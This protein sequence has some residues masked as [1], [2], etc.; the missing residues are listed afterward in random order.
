LLRQPTVRL[1]LICFNET[2]RISYCELDKHVELLRI[3]FGTIKKKLHFYQVTPSARLHFPVFK[4]ECCFCE[5]Q[6]SVVL[7]RNPRIL[8]FSAGTRK[9]VPVFEAEKRFRF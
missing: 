8:N 7:L 6:E 1:W 3:N 5:I 4:Q 9:N 2:F